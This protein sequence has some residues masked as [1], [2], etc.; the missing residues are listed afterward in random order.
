[1]NFIPHGADFIKKFVVIRFADGFF[2]DRHRFFFL[3]EPEAPQRHRIVVFVGCL[4]PEH[5]VV[6]CEDRIGSICNRWVL[7]YA[8]NAGRSLQKLRS[9]NVISVRQSR[10]WV[11]Q[12]VRNPR[13]LIVILQR[14][15]EQP[16]VPAD[17]DSCS[18]ETQD[19]C[20]CSPFNAQKYRPDIPSKFVQTVEIINLSLP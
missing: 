1:M 7:L 6:L 2:N 16:S 18:P 17:T 4:H 8:V 19:S 13:R 5:V 14:R 11:R 10:L 3:I 15:L 9:R 12:L 20:F